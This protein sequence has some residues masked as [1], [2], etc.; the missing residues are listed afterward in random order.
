M[1]AVTLYPEIKAFRLQTVQCSLFYNCFVSGSL[2]CIPSLLDLWH[3]IQH[4][5]LLCYP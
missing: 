2:N 3:D 4:G 5:S 1:E